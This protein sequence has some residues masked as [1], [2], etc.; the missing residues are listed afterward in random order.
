[1]S[2]HLNRAIILHDQGRHDL[3]IDEARLAL[4]ED[5][6]DS[7]AHALLASSL[8]HVEKFDEATREVHQAIH[9]DPDFAFAHS[10]H[11]SILTDRN[12]YTE[13]ASAIAEAIRLEPQ[14]PSHYSRSAAIQL[15]QSKWEE[16]LEDADRALALDPEHVQAT[17]LRALALMRLGRKAEAGQALDA[18]LSK[19]PDNATSHANR[20]WTLLEEG[21][22]EKAME[23]FREALRLDP[24][25]E[26]AREG[27]VEALKAKNVVYRGML[28]YFFFMQRLSGR[29]QWGVILGAYIGYR[30]VIS[31]AESH[32]A[33]APFAWPLI[34]CYLAFCL[35]S[36]LAKPL[37]DLL[38]RLN[39]FGRLALSEEQIR[40]S[41]WIGGALFA[42]L[43][44]SVGGYFL[45]N[46]WI[47]FPGL[48]SL[49]MV[50]PLIGF[51][52]C[53]EGWPRK[54]MLTYT[55]IL[56]LIGGI[57]CSLWIGKTSDADITPMAEL[58]IVV[59]GLGS[60]LSGWVANGLMMV[61]PKR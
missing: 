58:L 35:M 29:G 17:N 46:S 34:G 13:A 47:F 24:E 25:L 49:F 4:A 48:F 22:H 9:L 18:A 28:K 3:A 51:F 61:R 7:F 41:N 33:W 36:W 45:D 15:Q 37:F 31:L 40:S 56:G 38:L 8:G 42:G 14:E 55:V 20:G 16:A 5:P 1:M 21:S 59:F 23:H 27:I 32:P 11:A 6:D 12:R 57:A 43:A 39:K 50:F 54:A 10:I 30:V 60:V 26:W 52:G 2:P 44:G 53:E 19:E